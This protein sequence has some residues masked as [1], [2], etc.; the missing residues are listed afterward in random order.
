[1]K[2]LY[3]SLF[4]L[5]VLL[6]SGATVIAQT[7]LDTVDDSLEWRF[8]V[9]LDDKEIGWHQFRI[10]PEGSRVNVETEARFD[11]KFLFITAYRYQHRNVEAWD[12][13]GLVSID[14]YTNA[15]GDEFIVQGERAGEHFTLSTGAEDAK[16]PAE[17]KSFC[18]WSPEILEANRL[19]NSQT[20]EY[21]P[22]EVIE[23]GEASIAYQ[24]EAIPAR[25]YDIMVK[26]LPI[27]IWYAVEDQRWL[28]LE[29][30]TEGGRTLRYEPVVLPARSVVNQNLL[31]FLD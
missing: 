29:S 27:S 2:H 6:L 4:S 28:A 12:S 9:F 15:N 31:T 26:G 17:L 13:M 7:S 23:R 24:G 22:V 25:Q 14:A 16:L 30:L 5:A 3:F 20:G 19:L 10:D 8:K 11:V 18:Y 1:M 21:E